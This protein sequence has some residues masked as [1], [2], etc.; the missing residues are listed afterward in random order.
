[1]EKVHVYGFLLNNKI[2]VLEKI[3]RQTEWTQIRLLQQEH[4]DLSPHCL[5]FQLLQ[6][7]EVFYLY[8]KKLDV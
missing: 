4:S 7:P 3:F 1:M 8:S 6:L 2:F 5:P